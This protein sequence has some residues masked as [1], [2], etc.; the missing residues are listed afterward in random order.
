[1][2]PETSKLLQFI[3][4]HWLLWLGFTITFG[5]LFFEEF[6]NNFKL[7]SNNSVTPQEAINLI[8]HEHAV[9]I[10]VRNS[11]DFETGSLVNAHNI[12]K[13]EIEKNNQKLTHYKEKAVILVATTGQEA[14]K[15]AKHLKAINFN[16]VYV[17]AEGIHSWRQANLPIVKK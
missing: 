9:V 7:T 17:L 15:V 14:Q 8:N 10:D 12:P 3:Q 4:N 16:K 13:E 6:K 1:M 11:Q 2:S 5:L